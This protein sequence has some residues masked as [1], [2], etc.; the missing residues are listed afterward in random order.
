MHLCYVDESGDSRHGTLL[1]AVL[2][3]NQHWS[4]LLG[5][6][7]Q[8]RRE[9]HKAFGVPKTKEI[10]ANQLYKGRGSYCDTLEQDL[11]FG[12]RNRASAGRM[13]LTELGKFENF[14]AITIGSSEISKP[15]AYARLIA[16]LEDWAALN[17]TQLMV[18]YDG[19]QGLPDPGEEASASKLH[20]L[21]ERAV[22]DAAPYREVHRDLD[23]S[24]RR[25][26]EDPIMQDSRYSQLIQVADLIAYGAFHKHKQEHPEIWGTKGTPSVG[27]IVAYMKLT[28]RWPVD[29]DYGTF[30][31]DD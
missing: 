2:V 1:T 31:L 3:E 10:H 20:E 28:R 24:N 4:G 9:I 18:F 22:R 25:I 7:L 15:K 5:A 26:V 6:W 13:L 17:D 23:L 30:W 12:T 16:W 8:G 21:W 19:Q 29:S 11:N 14:T 27:A